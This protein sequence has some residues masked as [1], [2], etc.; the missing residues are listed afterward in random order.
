MG[1]ENLGYSGMFALGQSYA[2]GQWALHADV[3]PDPSDPSIPEPAYFDGF[4]EACKGSSL[5]RSGWSQNETQAFHAEALAN[6]GQVRDLFAAYLA[7]GPLP[8]DDELNTATPGLWSSKDGISA[9][10]Y[11]YYYDNQS[12]YS[13]GGGVAA[14]GLTVGLQADAAK[15]VQIQ[16][17]TVNVGTPKGSSDPGA[18][19]VPREF[20]GQQVFGWRYAADHA[21]PPYDNTKWTAVFSFGSWVTSSYGD[22]LTWFMVVWGALLTIMTA[23]IGSAAL[24]ALAAGIATV[25]AAGGLALSAT[26]A[27]AASKWILDT[28]TALCA[29]AAKAATTG[30]STTLMQDLDTAAGNLESVAPYAMQA[31]QNAFPDQVAFAKN[32]ATSVS[33]VWGDAQAAFAQGTSQVAALTSSAQKLATSFPGIDSNYWNMASQVVGPGAGSYFLNL[34]RMAPSI[35]DLVALEGNMPWY[36]QGFVQ[37]GATIRAAEMAQY[38]RLTGG[39]VRA[40]PS[41]LVPPSKFWPPAVHA[42]GQALKSI[43]PPVPPTKTPAQIV[44]DAKAAGS[45]GGVVVAV[46]GLG[47]AYVLGW[48]KF[49]L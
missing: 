35:N 22:I 43:L 39:G 36:A 28:L 10:R 14:K 33:N 30:D 15:Y 13:Q 9:E 2:L 23:G 26:A 48:L 7:N 11:V 5:D 8:T 17:F 32:I 20:N 31:A 19:V 42:T 1:K 44:A 4:W 49:L 34:T 47:I 45:T 29:A 38:T 18:W 6:I 27:A 40:M 25:A 3:Q 16:G 12:N 37:F 21:G 41:A 46:A 24:P